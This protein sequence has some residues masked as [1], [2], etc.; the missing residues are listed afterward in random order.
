L[1]VCFLLQ[2]FQLNLTK[3][4][5]IKTLVMASSNFVRAQEC[6]AVYKI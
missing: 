5:N 6:V 3:K 4:Q 2:N 1:F